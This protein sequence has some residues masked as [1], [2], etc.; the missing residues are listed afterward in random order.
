MRISLVV[1]GLTE[2]T[3]RLQ[4]WRYISEL[5]AGLA[6]RGHAVEL[7]SETAPSRQASL[8]GVARVG[9]GS[10][11][12]SGGLTDHLLASRP[13][14]VLWN[15]GATSTLR[16]R[17]DPRLR[18]RHVAIFTSPLYRPPEIGLAGADLA[19]HPMSYA[20]LGVGALIPRRMVARYLARSFAHVVVPGTTTARQLVAGGLPRDRITLLPPG[21]DLDVQPVR[22]SNS[23]GDPLTFLYAGNPTPIRGPDLLVRAFARAAPALG[24]ARLVLLSRHDRADLARETDRLAALAARLGVDR[25]TEILP[26]TLSRAAL[27][28][29]LGR[30]DV[31]VL[32]F[33]LVPSEAPLTVL[34][35][36]GI[37]RR[38]IGS[39]LPGVRDLAAPGS[40]LVPPGDVGRLA[41]ALAGCAADPTLTRRLGLEASRWY[42]R[43]PTWSEVAEQLERRLRMLLGP[44]PTAGVALAPPAISSQSLG[45]R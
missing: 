7:L 44:A 2:A 19:S 25:Q 9:L 22:A 10:L 21:R 3:E 32:P 11:G 24:G 27:L 13:D 6:G 12:R 15:V 38:L 39:A 45:A 26:G 16:L 5:A 8:E 34:E 30:A 33:R 18:A 28:A 35:A 31:I 40:W 29:A 23:A 43:W 1:S 41:R 37:G 20:A 4:P 14:L 17:P 36:A 42:A